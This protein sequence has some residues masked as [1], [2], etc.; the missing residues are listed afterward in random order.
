[1][2]DADLQTVPDE[3]AQVLP[4]SPERM[5]RTGLPPWAGAKAKP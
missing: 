5:Q 3:I 2:R 4:E 1:M